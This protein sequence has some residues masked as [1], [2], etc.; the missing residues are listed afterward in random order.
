MKNTS[1]LNTN[2]SSVDNE[3][4]TTYVNPFQL[5]DENKNFGISESNEK[6]KKEKSD[7]FVFNADVEHKANQEIA[8]IWKNTRHSKEKEK[9]KKEKQSRELKN[10]QNPKKWSMEGAHLEPKRNFQEDA[11]RAFARELQEQLDMEANES[12]LQRDGMLALMLQQAEKEQ[13]RKLQRLR[14]HRLRKHLNPRSIDVDRMLTRNFLLWKNE[15]AMQNHTELLKKR[16]D[17]YQLP[18][19]KK[20]MKIFTG[21]L[22]VSLILK[23]GIL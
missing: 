9:R 21:V 7:L 15:L 2:N 18:L 10:Q 14:A 22:F 16:F 4:S 6:R 12:V 1:R 5:L 20:L 19:W 11:D 3:I 8:K 17:L 13:M 23:K